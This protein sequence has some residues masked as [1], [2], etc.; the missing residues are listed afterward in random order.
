MTAE[1]GEGRGAGRL[2]EERFH[3]RH[4]AV[5]VEEAEEDGPLLGV[6]QGAH[7]R[8][9]SGDGSQGSLETKSP[10]KGPEGFDRFRS[11]PE[12]NAFR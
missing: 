9:V 12:G 1:Q 7:R 5:Q 6:V 10:R 11:L 3:V 8:P 2:C 4:A